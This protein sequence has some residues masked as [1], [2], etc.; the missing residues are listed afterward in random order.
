MRWNIVFLHFDFNISNCWNLIWKRKILALCEPFSVC[1][2]STSK[3]SS[4]TITTTTNPLLYLYGFFSH[5][6]CCQKKLI[7]H[8]FRLPKTKSFKS[9]ELQKFLAG[10]KAISILDSSHSENAMVLL[11]CYNFG[12]FQYGYCGGRTLQATPMAHRFSL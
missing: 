4:H 12:L 7:L 3:I 6:P 8:D 10:R 5:A 9:R 2:L 11:V 1:A